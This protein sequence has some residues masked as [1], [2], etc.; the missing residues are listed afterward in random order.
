VI[1]KSALSSTAFP[2]VPHGLAST[3][4]LGGP[5]TVSRLLMENDLT[6]APNGADQGKRSGKNFHDLGVA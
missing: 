2:V 4:E 1:V 5:R 3:A 6:I